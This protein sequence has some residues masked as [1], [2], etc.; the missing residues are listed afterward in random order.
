MEKLIAINLLTFNTAKL[1][2]VGYFFKRLFEALP[3]V[4]GAQF[5]FFCQPQFPLDEVIRIPDG[6]QY[7]RVDVPQFKSKVARIAYEQLIMPFRLRHLNVLYSPCVANPLFSPGTR[8]ITTIYDLTPF[9][10]PD[11]YGWV[12]RW[13]V[14]SI[15]RLLARL[16]DQIITT[17]ESSKRD[18]MEVLGVNG[19][20]LD[21]VYPFVPRHDACNDIRYEPFFL[22]VGT[23][24]P[25]KNVAGVIRAFA[26][27]SRELDSEK[28][29]L[30]VVGG[31]ER[32][33]QCAD[34]AGDLGILDRVEF[35]GYIDEEELNALY[36]R[37]KAHITLSFY[38]GFGIP[39]LEAL[40]W[41]KPSVA[42][43]ISS[44][45]EV[46]GPT[47]I[48]VDPNDLPAAAQAI[49][50]IADEPQKYLAG[51]Q[52]QLDKFS[53]E[54][55]VRRFLHVLGLNVSEDA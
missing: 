52:H 1:T 8:R 42:S 40:S 15:T 22:T 6:I 12:Q 33:D 51:L 28:H 32:G 9:F 36:A 38:E 25:A 45:P 7:R 47:G 27:F 24:Q 10:V 29:K 48:K 19:K 53:A 43:N 41:R 46:M 31:A 50:A 44:L 2:G 54:Q 20:K 18:L 13:Y 26:L 21:V 17:S 30:I 4:P 16:S 35:R 39:V 5:V 14:R 55:Q 49:K 3:P 34:L 11:K 37:C 23:R